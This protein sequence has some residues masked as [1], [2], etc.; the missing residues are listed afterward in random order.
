VFLQELDLVEKSPPIPP[1]A[2]RCLTIHSAKGLE[3]EHV[4]IAGLAE[5]QLPSFQSIKKGDHSI[6]MQEERRNCFVAITRAQTSLTL[7]YARRYSGWPKQP[8]RFLREM[9]LLEQT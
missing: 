4:Y 1:D 8:S 7:S 9:E 6:E 3:W 5:D 2:V